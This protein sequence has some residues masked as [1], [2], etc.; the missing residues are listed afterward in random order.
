M[1]SS[2]VYKATTVPFSVLMLIIIITFFNSHKE[3]PSAFHCRNFTD[4]FISPC[5]ISSILS[6]SFMQLS[7]FYLSIMYLSIYIL[8]LSTWSS[9]HIHNP[10]QPSISRNLN[11]SIQLSIYT[12]HSFT[13]PNIHQLVLLIVYQSLDKFLHSRLHLS[14][15]SCYHSAILHSTY[16]FTHSSFRLLNLPSNYL[17]IQL[18]LH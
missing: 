5:T 3:W 1:R 18:L 8:L 2:L 14:N 16:S 13:H 6:I 17:I 10:V 15:H 11:L 7:T 12:I 9:I 4:P